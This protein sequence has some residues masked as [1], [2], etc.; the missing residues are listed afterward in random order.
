M[1]TSSSPY[2]SSTSAKVPFRS[3]GASR[4][5]WRCGTRSTAWISSTV[6]LPNSDRRLR[7]PVGSGRALPVDRYWSMAY[8]AFLPAATA[9]T[10][11]AAPV[12]TSPPA[13]TPST[14]VSKVPPSTCRVSQ[15]VNRRVSPAGTRSETP[16]PTS[17][18]M[19]VLCPM[20]AMTKSQGI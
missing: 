20:A 15:R 12:T 11:V 2:P 16:V 9:S 17:W 5:M 7:K 14:V 18:R 3:S 13:K 10:T 19:V 4:G 1:F 6:G 8:A